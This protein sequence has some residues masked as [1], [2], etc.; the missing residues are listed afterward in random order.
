MGGR[1]PRLERQ[2][3]AKNPV[4]RQ[5]ESSRGA[6]DVEEPTSSNT[7]VL[8]I[9]DEFDALALMRWSEEGGP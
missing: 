2:G 9:D 4:E 6:N 5:D 1:A 7:D 8:E 3:P